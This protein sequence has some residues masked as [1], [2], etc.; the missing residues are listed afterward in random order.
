MIDTVILTIPKSKTV[1]LSPAGERTVWDL[2]SRN[3][4]YSK[5][6]INPSV[7]QK[8][9]GFYFPRLTGYRRKDDITGFSEALRI[10][11]SPPKLLYKNNLDELDEPQFDDVVKALR[12]RL[13]QMGVKVLT[14]GIEN[15]MVSAVHYSKNIQLQ[16][17]YTAQYVIG[18]LLRTTM[19]KNCKS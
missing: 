9:S 8:A 12:E 7:A 14:Q 4:S 11:F 16:D 6:I 18:E 5:Y 10:E 1:M 13:G 19:T 3:E 15:A 17:G 2:Q